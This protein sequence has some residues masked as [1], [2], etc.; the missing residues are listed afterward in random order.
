MSRAARISGGV[1]LVLLVV[2]GLARLESDRTLTRTTFGTAPFGFKAVFDLFQ[3]SEV[4]VRRNLGDP[5]DLPEGSTV[6]WILPTSLCQANGTDSGGRAVEWSGA[7]WLERGGTAV[8]FLSGRP[9]PQPCPFLAGLSLPRRSRLATPEG[10]GDERPRRPTSRSLAGLPEEGEPLAVE[11]AVAPR[12]R[13][14]T[15]ADLVAFDEVGD[16]TVAARV[17]DRPFVLERSSGAGRVIA[18][19]DAAFLSNAW[20]DCAD[21]APLAMDLART[22]G[23]PLIDERDHGFGEDPGTVA[24]LARSPAAIVFA[25]LAM[26]GLAFTWWGAALPPRTAGGAETPA[27]TLESYVTSLATLYAR[28]GDHAAAAT[29]YRDFALSQLRRRLNLSP[30]TPPE[31][32]VAR[33]ERQHRLGPEDFGPLLRQP[34]VASAADL[35]EFGR[36]LDDLVRKASR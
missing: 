13:M 33:L 30:D 32:V 20:L 14:L 25:G 16:W 27:P 35:R 15:V 22:Y 24:Y 26:L 19:A 34:A 36:A 10:A 21:A 4:P 12:A 8:V 5:G 28:S 1:L 2:V 9:E 7:T 11:G 17:G 18:V 3:E 29:Q 31:A 6:W 23:P